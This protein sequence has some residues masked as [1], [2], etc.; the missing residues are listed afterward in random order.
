VPPGGVWRSTLSAASKRPVRHDE[1]SMATVRWG[2]A[3]MAAM[4]DLLRGSGYQVDIDALP[5]E[6]PG[7]GWTSFDTWAGQAFTGG[8]N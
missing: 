6:Q 5:H 1:V 7:V 3:D 4:W 2:S 8:T